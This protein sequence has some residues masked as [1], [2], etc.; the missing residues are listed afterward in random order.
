L[1][2]GRIS[3]LAGFIVAIVGLSTP[4]ERVHAILTL[5]SLSVQ[6]VAWFGIFILAD[7]AA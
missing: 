5:F 2:A 7:S 1:H 4:S 3:Q 6:V